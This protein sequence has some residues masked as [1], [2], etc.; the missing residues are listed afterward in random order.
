MCKYRNVRIILYIF[1]SSTVSHMIQL[2]PLI[3]EGTI[4]GINIIYILSIPVVATSGLKLKIKGKHEY[5][6]SL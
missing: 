3:L 4:M 1:F 6:N 5:F 2:Y